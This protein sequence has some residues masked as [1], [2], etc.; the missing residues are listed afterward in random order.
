[1]AS[2]MLFLDSSDLVL[3]TLGMEWR[4]L[5]ERE[6][7]FRREREGV[8]EWCKTSVLSWRAETVL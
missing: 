1:M 4:R 3:Y 6:K 8:S 2:T 5:E 7:G